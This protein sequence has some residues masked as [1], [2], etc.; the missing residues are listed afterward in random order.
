MANRYI[1][2]T[3]RFYDK[4]SA[5]MEKAANRVKGVTSKLMQQHDQYAKIGKQL[6][7]TGR[8]MARTGTGLTKSV[9]APIAGIVGASLRAGTEFD[10]QMSK[11]QAIS[12][13]TSGELTQLRDKAKE[14][15]ATTKFSATEAGQALEYMAMAGWKTSDMKAG[16]SGVMNLAA[17]SGE[18]LAMVSDIVTDG[19][20]AFKMGA[21]ESER[22]A[23]VLAKTASSANTNVAMMGETFKYVAP[24]AGTLGYS[25][26]DMAKV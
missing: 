6:D 2:A 17:A 8:N 11:V 18:D 25:V 15:G 9:T 10:A 26:E 16:L 13:A 12:G 5:P 7:R 14:M 1:N 20:T 4:F 22:F 24:V 19:L 23:D 21:D 3:L